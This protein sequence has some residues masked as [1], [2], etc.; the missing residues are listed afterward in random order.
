MSRT[1]QALV[2]LTRGGQRR[3]RQVL[4]SAVHTYL[5]EFG[6]DGAAAALQEEVALALCGH[7]YC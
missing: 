1:Q 6:Y 4:N 7:A 2:W 5:K 3:Q